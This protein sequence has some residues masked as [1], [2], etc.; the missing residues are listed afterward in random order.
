MTYI[1]IKK[2]IIYTLIMFIIPFASLIFVNWRIVLAMRESSNL[3]SKMNSAKSTDQNVNQA[4]V[5][6][7]NF[8][9]LKS[10]PYAEF[11]QTLSKISNSNF[12]KPSTEIF[13]TKFTNSWKDRSVTLMLLA[14]VALFLSLNGLA[15]CNSIIESVMLIRSN[16]S[17]DDLE[18]HLIALFESSASFE[19]N[20][21]A[22]IFVFLG[23]NFE[24]FNHFKQ[25]HINPCLHNIQLQVPCNL[26]V[27]LRN[28]EKGK[29]KRLLIVFVVVFVRK[30]L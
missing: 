18:A 26:Q 16:D 10:R 23:W 5:L 17:Q 13:K 15:F 28:W 27:T 3:R 7:K 11:F 30:M 24:R 2:T 12:L 25:L 9:I 19:N 22:L 21:K 1:V 20:T 14:I 4:D 6:I 8:R 29:G